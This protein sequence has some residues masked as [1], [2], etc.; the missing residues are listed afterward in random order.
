MQWR[1]HL[2]GALRE[3]KAGGSIEPVLHNVSKVNGG[4]G[5][6]QEDIPLEKVLLSYILY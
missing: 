2:V 3:M 5:D 1:D 6:L 4:L